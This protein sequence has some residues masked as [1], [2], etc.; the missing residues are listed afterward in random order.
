MLKTRPIL[1]ALILCLAVLGTVSCENAPAATDPPDKLKSVDLGTIKL[2]LTDFSPVKPG[3]RAGRAVG[4]DLL[5][6]RLAAFAVTVT[7]DRDGE[8]VEPNK[9]VIASIITEDGMEYPVTGAARGGAHG[10]FTLPR[11]YGKRFKGNTLLL[12]NINDRSQSTTLKLPDFP[13]EPKVIADKEPRMANPPWKVVTRQPNQVTIMP[14]KPPSTKFWSIQILRSSYMD[15]REI[16]PRTGIP[17]MLMSNMPE[18]NRFVCDVDPKA[19]E[20]EERTYEQQLTEE[21]MTTPPIRVEVIHGSPVIVVEKPIS[22]TTKTGCR[23][24]IPAQKDAPFRAGKT[25]NRAVSLRYDIIPAAPQASL[26]FNKSSWIKEFQT[27]LGRYGIQTLHLIIGMGDRKLTYQPGPI[28]A[29]EFSLKLVVTNVD[30][31]SLTV[32]RGIVPV[33]KSYTP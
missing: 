3:D 18:F 23:I 4:L 25:P 12:H 17:R 32:R 31:R 1:S 7:F 6:D 24:E 30:Y 33:D 10:V 29:G 21:I 22:L 19:V 14:I 26:G 11:G 15:F 28:K 8:L 16:D 13:E 5:C 20:L 2:Y 27:D 9:T